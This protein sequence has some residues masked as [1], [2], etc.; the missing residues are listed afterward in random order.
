MTLFLLTTPTAYPD[1]AAYVENREIVLATIAASKVSHAC[2][3]LAPLQ[4][5]CAGAICCKRRPQAAATQGLARLG[6]LMVSPHSTP[7]M[8]SQL[9]HVSRESW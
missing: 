1:C 4:A 7:S 9:V 5:P 6:S 3:A 8:T 2:M